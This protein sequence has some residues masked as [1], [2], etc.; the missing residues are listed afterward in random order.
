MSSARRAIGIGRSVYDAVR[1]TQVTFLAAAIAYYGFL[2]LVP[3][4][5][6]AIGVGD[7]LGYDLST[8]VLGA[9]GDLVTPAGRAALA[10]AIDAQGGGR[11]L[12]LVG[13]GALLW[14]SVRVFRA[15]D[16]AIGRVYG[17]RRT[18]S[19]PATLLDAVVV[20]SL[21][22]VAVAVTGVLGVVVPTLLDGPLALVVGPAT[23]ALTLFGVFVALY[24]R[25]TPAPIGPREAA[26]GAVLAAVGWSALAVGFGAY[27]SRFAGFH[28]YG[29][30]G[31]ALLLVTWL[32]ASGTI[33]MVGA[34]LNAVL[35]GRT[36]DD[37]SEDDERRADPAPDVATLGREV[38]SLRETVE[39]R[40]VSRD[41]LEAD[42]GRYVR[43]RVRRGK[44]RGWGPYLV[45]LYGTL[46]TLGAFFW[47]EGGWAIAAM[48]V[49][50]LS[51]L[52][53]YVLMVLFGIGM[54]ATGLP[55]RLLERIGR[56][57]S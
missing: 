1:E 4:A 29:V 39:D 6:L 24:W 45:L 13:L 51:T 52:G 23:L 57:R 17:A 21:I 28:L 10:T 35:A 12:T 22:P 48:I 27:A 33:I 44:A 47:L 56:W 50:W 8:E 40:T 11:G 5:L 9:V 55:G 31:A 16:L 54:A 36:D 26:P 49:V 34:V 38:E 42:L 41:D 19:L 18:A 37:A 7:A 32:Y 14:S 2:S 30:L 43:R 53:L 15:L 20:L 46:M 3:L 25:V